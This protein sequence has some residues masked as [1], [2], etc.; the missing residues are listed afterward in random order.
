[1]EKTIFI[2]F[3]NTNNIE[4]RGTFDK[5]LFIND[6][7]L[8]LNL[9]ESDDKEKFLETLIIII[10]KFREPKL[11]LKR[12]YK[13]EDDSITYTFEELQ[14]YLCDLRESNGRFNF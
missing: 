3:K 7:K 12:N 6:Y 1:M 10:F 9:M 14:E 13:E 8:D 4:L 2:K 11:N 5:D